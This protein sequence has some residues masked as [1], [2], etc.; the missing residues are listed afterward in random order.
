[1][2]PSKT[3]LAAYIKEWIEDHGVNQAWLAKKVGI[4]P[5]VMGDVISRGAIPR[6]ATLRR[7]AVAM[8]EPF[9]TLLIKAGYLSPRDLKVSATDGLDERVAR[10]LAGYPRSFQ[11]A[12]MRDI[13]PALEQVSYIVSDARAGYDPEKR[14]ALATAG[15][16][17]KSAAPPRSVEPKPDPDPDL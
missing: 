3:E 8:S 16:R 1:M 17:K 11:K 5:S 9:P 15:R 14:G 4:H 6:P 2:E 7:I 10:W 12:L 13:V